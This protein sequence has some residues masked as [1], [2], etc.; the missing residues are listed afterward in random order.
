MIIFLWRFL[1]IYLF[2]SL[3]VISTPLGGEAKG[4]PFCLISLTFFPNMFCINFIMNN[5][6]VLIIYLIIQAL[7]IRNFGKYIFFFFWSNLLNVI[8]EWYFKLKPNSFMRQIRFNLTKPK[9]ASTRPNPTLK[10][11]LRPEASFHIRSSISGPNFNRL[12]ILSDSQAQNILE[13]K[14]E[15]FFLN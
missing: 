7:V 14:S 4:F 6:H 8:V 13:S 12:Q 9:W 1:F 11:S 2:F 3:V 5:S 15:L 10:I